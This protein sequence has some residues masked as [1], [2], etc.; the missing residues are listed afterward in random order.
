MFLASFSVACC[1]GRVGDLGFA[2]RLTGG[3][4]TVVLSPPLSLSL[5]LAGPECQQADERAGPVVG[6]L[7]LTGLAQ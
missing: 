4:L 2:G 3:E 6:R 5:W 1:G 7:G